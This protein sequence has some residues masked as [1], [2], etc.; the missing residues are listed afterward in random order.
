[1]KDPAIEVWVSVLVELALVALAVDAYRL[2][3]K[4]FE[5]RLEVAA[6]VPQGLQFETS[7]APAVPLALAAILAL[8]YAALVAMALLMPDYSV[9]DQSRAKFTQRADGKTY[10]NPRYGV[11]LHMP[12][13]WDFDRSDPDYIVAGKTLEG[14]CQVGLLAE[15]TLPFVS[16]E[17]AGNSLVQQVLS[18]QK[19]FRLVERKEAT[20]ARQPAHEVVF[21][22]DVEGTEVIQ[23][24]V[25]ARRGLSRY[26]LII[27][28]ATVLAEDCEADIGAIRQSLV[29]TK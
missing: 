22:A 3:K 24:Y 14:G 11:E 21:S 8:A 2:A 9:I 20:L 25:L 7:L 13:A 6:A 23:H 10:L 16:L 19:N 17:M 5:G 12:A 1:M 28:M 15:A 18:M 27:T 29:L 26:A 4:D